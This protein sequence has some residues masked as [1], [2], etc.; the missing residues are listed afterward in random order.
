VG[1]T[2]EFIQALFT[3][4]K[5]DA[6]NGIPALVLQTCKVIQNPSDI[7][8]MFGSLS[9]IDQLLNEVYQLTSRTLFFR[10]DKETLVASI[11]NA[12]IIKSLKIVV[13]LSL[14]SSDSSLLVICC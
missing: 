11:D 6:L 13:M 9:S 8:V 1:V 10:H 7:R 2:A 12:T 4:M 3:E 14:F 5:T